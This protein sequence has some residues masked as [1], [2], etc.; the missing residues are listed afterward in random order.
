METNLSC[1]CKHSWLQI[2]VPSKHFLP[3]APFISLFH[4]ILWLF[5]Y[6]TQS[7]FLCDICTMQPPGSLCDVPTLTCTVDFAVTWERRGRRLTKRRE[8]FVHREMMKRR[9]QRHWNR[10]MKK[11]NRHIIWTQGWTED[12]T[13]SHLRVFMIKGSKYISINVW[14]KDTSYFFLPF[15]RICFSKQWCGAF[16]W[17]HGLIWSDC[18]G[19]SQE[20]NHVSRLPV[21]GRFHEDGRT[22]GDR[23]VRDGLMG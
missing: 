12:T 22:W 10:D 9:K 1:F 20:I 2:L 21:N 19:E 17:P 18:S 8:A 7:T 3:N 13:C 6:F 23:W 16:V 14:V 4:D 11:G 15:E 5:Y